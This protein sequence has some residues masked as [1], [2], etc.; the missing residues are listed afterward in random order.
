M[1]EKPNSDGKITQLNNHN[2]TCTISRK[3]LNAK[4]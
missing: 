4:I 2:D 3:E 1:I